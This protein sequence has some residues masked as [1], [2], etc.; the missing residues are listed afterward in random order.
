MF[1]NSHTRA[2]VYIKN[3][4]PVP[5]KLRKQIFCFIFNS[6]ELATAILYLNDYEMNL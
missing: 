4:S 6:L 2:F 5:T 1:A 3:Y